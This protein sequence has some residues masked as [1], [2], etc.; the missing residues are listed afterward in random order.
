MM[1]LIRSAFWL[2][3]VFSSMP[4]DRGEALRAVDEAQGVIV[5]DA[6]AAARAKCLTDMVSC[7][8]IIN[9]ASGAAFAA[10]AERSPPPRIPV[11]G[12]IARPSAD[13]LSAADLA[14]PW[15]G[16]QARAGA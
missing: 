3:I 6:V 4:F 1:F 15:R 14:A 9:A 13:T 7:R 12:K 2:G 16:K 5:A 11:K 10:N 8:A